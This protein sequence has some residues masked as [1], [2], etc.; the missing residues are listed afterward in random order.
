MAA[1]F[2]AAAF[3]A[4]FL[5][6]AFLAAGFLAAAFLAAGFLAAA[7]FA[8]GFLA[9]GFFA[10]GFFAAGYR[11]A[12]LA[13]G[14][15]AA[16]FLAAGFLAAGF[17]AAGFLAVAMWETPQV[18]GANMETRTRRPLMPGGHELFIGARTRTARRGFP[19]LMNSAQ[20]KRQVTRLGA[21]VEESAK[22]RA[23]TQPALPVLGRVAVAVSLPKGALC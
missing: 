1:G 17:F 14:F 5:A 23:D 9:A 15:L 2:F 16:A 4:G 7:F 11:A 3:L 18:D 21:L 6:A 19:T 13:A 20:Q 12:F 8:A 22:A 10:A